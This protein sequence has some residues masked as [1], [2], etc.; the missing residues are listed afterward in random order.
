M[1]AILTILLSARD[2]GDFTDAAGEWEMA[3][4]CGNLPR[5]EGD[6]VGL[7]GLWR[8]RVRIVQYPDT[9][10]I[11]RSVGCIVHCNPFEH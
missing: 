1:S 4:K 3:P 2:A 5:D 6:L 8:V 10:P 7:I 9:G 11:A